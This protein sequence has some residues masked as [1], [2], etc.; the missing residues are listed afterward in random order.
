MISIAKEIETEP[1]MV[2]TAPHSTRTSRVDEVKAARKPVLKWTP[3][4]H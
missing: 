1:E 3:V 4:P 2:K